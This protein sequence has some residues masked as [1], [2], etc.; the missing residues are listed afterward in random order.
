M[1]GSDSS[2]LLP[3]DYYRSV[4]TP[5][6]SDDDANLFLQSIIELEDLKDHVIKEID[7][8]AYA[9]PLKTALF[10]YRRKPHQCRKFVVRA[11]G[12]GTNTYYFQSLAAAAQEAFHAQD[13]YLLG[14]I[15][16]HFES[17][18]VE[19]KKLTEF[20]WFDII[21]DLGH[22]EL[23]DQKAESLQL[24]DY[25]RSTSIDK[26]IRKLE[27]AFQRVLLR[28]HQHLTVKQLSAAACGYFTVMPKHFVIPPEG[29]KTETTNWSILNSFLAEPIQQLLLDENLRQKWE[30][31]THPVLIDK[32]HES[33]S[34]QD[35]DLSALDA[36]VRKIRNPFSKIANRLGAEPRK[37]NPLV[38]NNSDKVN[39]IENSETPLETVSQVFDEADD[40]APTNEVEETEEATASTSGVW[41]FWKRKE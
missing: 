40:F 23:S 25:F 1:N 21:E 34:E 37:K 17:S 28:S 32:I 11:I 35:F 4:K 3:I 30:D 14:I 12:W 31:L 10:L 7:P 16:F 5:E 6:Y 19:L 9:V 39:Q 38:N 8:N 15:A 20:K 27:V 36:N 22:V 18:Q 41:N 29:A 33:S 26:V 24:M 13:Y 2:M